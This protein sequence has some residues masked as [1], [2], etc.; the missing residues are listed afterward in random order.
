M[1]VLLMVMV[2][3]EAPKAGCRWFTGHRAHE[4]VSARV[5]E[6]ESAKDTATR[7]GQ[8]QTQVS[9]SATVNNHI[10]AS[11]A[12]DVMATTGVCLY[13]RLVKL[14]WKVSF[15]WYFAITLESEKSKR[16]VSRLFS[17]FFHSRDRKKGDVS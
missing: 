14:T 7:K 15:T 6:R 9:E 17:H 12:T 16:G 8:N 10:E 4:A 2:K 13:W 5:R 3:R 11:P 1:M